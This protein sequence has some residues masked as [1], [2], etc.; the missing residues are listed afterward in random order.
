MHL[1]YIIGGIVVLFVLYLIGSSS[2]NEAVAP[3]FEGD[4]CEEKY[5][6]Y[7]PR[8]DYSPPPV[9]R[10]WES[11][12]EVPLNARLRLMY[13]NAKSE[14]SSR[15]V[16]ISR[17]D[18]SCYLSGF[19]EYR[20]ESRTFR[21][22]RIQ[23][24]IDEGTGEIVQNVPN[25]LLKK[26]ECSPEYKLKKVFRDHID[27]IRVLYYVGKADGQLRKEEREI[28]YRTIHSTTKDE[29]IDYASVIHELN[30]LSIPSLQAFKMAVGRI[31]KASP[32]RMKTTYKIAKKI[33]DTQKNVHPLEK[34][35]LE[36]MKG[37]MEKEGVV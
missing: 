27:V 4:N 32:K 8:H 24:C 20:N 9:E 18:G 6:S 31:C 11:I 16:Q 1:E 3:V 34:E 10:Y 21:I 36:Y 19:C 15:T 17:Y 29:R 13:K 37:R 28:I 7:Q 2:K 12:E 23:E 30:K 22:D 25:H 26:Y 35:A 5:N 33:V 14:V